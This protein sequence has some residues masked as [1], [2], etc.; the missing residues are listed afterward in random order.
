MSYTPVRVLNFD[1]LP[2]TNATNIIILQMGLLLS[3]ASNLEPINKTLADSRVALESL[4]AFAALQ[5][6]ALQ[7]IDASLSA[8]RDSLSTIA[9]LLSRTQSDTTVSAPWAFTADVRL[10][11]VIDPSNSTVYRR[12]PIGI[13]DPTLRYQT[14]SNVGSDSVEVKPVCYIPG[15]TTYMQYQDGNSSYPVRP[16][17]YQARTVI[18]NR[19]SHPDT[20]N[21]GVRVAP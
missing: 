15:V 6:T 20:S 12:F 2:T 19:F 4:R 14:D 10:H 11:H 9:D 16:N 3:V 1:D 21:L 17:A 7:S 18:N 5:T 8:V 13:I